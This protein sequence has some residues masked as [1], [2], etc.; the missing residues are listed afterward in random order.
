[1]Y[2]GNAGKPRLTWVGKIYFPA[3]KEDLAAVFCVDAG[4]D[5]HQC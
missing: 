1:M 5:F 4:Y 2:D 3:I